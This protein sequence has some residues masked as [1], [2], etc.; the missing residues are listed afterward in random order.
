MFLSNYIKLF[1]ETVLFGYYVMANLKP[2]TIQKYCILY[3]Y[4]HTFIFFALH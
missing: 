2:V 1:H 4:Y 3:K